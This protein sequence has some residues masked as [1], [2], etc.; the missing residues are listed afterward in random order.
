MLLVHLK[1]LRN[2]FNHAHPKKKQLKAKMDQRVLFQQKEKKEYCL[3]QK[4][5][6]LAN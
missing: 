3:K 6:I 5:S 2:Q 4:D 1:A